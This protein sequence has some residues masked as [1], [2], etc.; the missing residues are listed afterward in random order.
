MPRWIALTDSIA[1]DPPK[2]KEDLD[3]I[4]KDLNRVAKVDPDEA[5]CAGAAL[6]ASFKLMQMIRAAGYQDKPLD[7][8]LRLVPEWCRADS[9]FDGSLSSVVLLWMSEEFER[10]QKTTGTKS[11]T[12]RRRGRPPKK[13]L[14]VG[15]AMQAAL[16]SG[17]ITREELASLSA[18]Q[19]GF[20]FNADPKTAD[21]AR[22]YVLGKME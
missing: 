13:R 3:E 1:V 9:L 17:G 14:A 18:Y 7:F 4:W 8:F 6:V 16:R 11:Q 2:S 22:K 15:N 12:Q 21:A 20:E 5:A 19:L 10:R